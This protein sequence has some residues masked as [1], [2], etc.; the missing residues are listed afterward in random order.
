MTAHT[1]ANYRVHTASDAERLQQRTA[2]IAQLDQLGTATEAE[3]DRVLA[4]RD[5]AKPEPELDAETISQFRSMIEES[6]A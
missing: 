4:E 5:P 6:R 1:V 2:F 3:I